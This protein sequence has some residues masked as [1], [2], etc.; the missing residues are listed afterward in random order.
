MKYYRI[1][2]VYVIKYERVEARNAK[3]ALIS[4]NNIYVPKHFIENGSHHHAMKVKY[5][6]ISQP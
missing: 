5:M 3:V 2:F 6:M 1:D 4:A